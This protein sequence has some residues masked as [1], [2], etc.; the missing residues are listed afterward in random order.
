MD[1]ITV[2]N[3]PIDYEDYFMWN[4]VTDK[5]IAGACGMAIERLRRQLGQR[6]R[7]ELERMKREAKLGA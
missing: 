1:K 4:G 5:S 3:S 7:R 2:K 6:V